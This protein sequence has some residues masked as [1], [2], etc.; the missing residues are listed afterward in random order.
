MWGIVDT[1]AEVT[2]I[3]ERVFCSI[4]EKYRPDVT[5]A[6]RNLVVAEEGRNLPTDGIAEVEFTL[7]HYT[8][9]WT[10]YIAPIADYI[11]LGCDIVDELNLTINT[12]QGIHHVMSN[13][14]CSISLAS[15][16]FRQ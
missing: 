16:Y 3:A 7:S 1:G 9:R 6:P 14:T 11:L 4:P 13:T 15:P 8:F 12:R 5:K 10:V 2:V